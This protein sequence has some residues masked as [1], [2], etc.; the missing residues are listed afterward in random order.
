[1]SAKNNIKGVKYLFASASLVTAIGL[2]NHFSSQAALQEQALQKNEPDPQVSYVQKLEFP[3]LPTLVPGYE[4]QAS[5]LYQQPE[6]L[7]YSN[8]QNSTGQLREALR[9]TPEAIPN[10]QVTINQVIIG[11]SGGNTPSNPPVNNTG[12]SK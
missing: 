4:D 3:P 5:V 7:D 1:M 10:P 6:Q 8:D 12:S 9:P 2:W 11:Q